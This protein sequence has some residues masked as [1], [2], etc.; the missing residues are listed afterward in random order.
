MFRT[1]LVAA[2]GTAFIASSAGVSA[3]TLGI[4]ACD[5]FLKK[6]ETCVTSQVPVAQRATFQGQ[7]DQWRKAW[8]DMAKN[9]NTK[10]GLENACKQSAE[11][12]KTAMSGFGCK[13]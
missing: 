10:A 7:F 8:S 3:Q 9:P 11:Q 12:M 5:D 13:F 4:A 1:S 2:A 6:Y